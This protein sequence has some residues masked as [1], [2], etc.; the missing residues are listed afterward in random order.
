VLHTG[1]GWSVV[2]RVPAT[3]SEEALA[4]DLLL[5]EG[6]LVHPGYFFDFPH[7]AF[8]VLSLL[9]PEPVFADAVARVARRASGAA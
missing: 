9:P 6:V 7:E 8:L 4:L 1:G 3:Q 2:M 5:K